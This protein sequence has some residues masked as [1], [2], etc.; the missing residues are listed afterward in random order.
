M[1]GRPRAFKSAEEFD[2]KINRYIESISEERLLTQ[3]V[4]DGT[5]INDDG[6]EV[7]SYKEVPWLDSYGEQRKRRVFI[8]RPSM[9]GAALHMGVNKT[10]LY[11]Y[12]DKEGFS[13]SLKRLNTV[14]EKYK[15]DE[16]YRTQG[17]V[18]GI[19]FDLKNNHGWKDKT[20]VAATVSEI[21]ISEKHGKL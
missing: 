8:E 6:E 20:E 17:Q 3:K 12:A 13:N 9:L 19:I 2:D 16:L 21:K 18:T 15:A 4:Q 10:T 1:N 11:E 7:P 5:K 14:I